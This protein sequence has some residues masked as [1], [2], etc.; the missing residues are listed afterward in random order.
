MSEGR[1][2]AVTSKRDRSLGFKYL[3]RSGKNVDLIGRVYTYNRTIAFVK[4]TYLIIV[5]LLF[6]N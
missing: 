2:D 5:K 4:I 1:R 6:Y 3:I